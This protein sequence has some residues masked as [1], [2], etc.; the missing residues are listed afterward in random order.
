MTSMSRA[1]GGAE[2]HAGDR[3]AAGALRVGA[4]LRRA[5]EER[6]LSLEEVARAL[7]CAARQVRAVEEGGTRD[8]P[9]HPYARGL[10]TAYASVV[11]LDPDAAAQEW[12]RP[13]GSPRRRPGAP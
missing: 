2:A 3:A 7:R 5:R 8:L 1:R 10:V 13:P 6:G 9:P 12:G 11:G 4:A